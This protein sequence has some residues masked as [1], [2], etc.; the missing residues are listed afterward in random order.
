[1][2]STLRSLA[3][4][5]A[6]G[7]PRTSSPRV[8]GRGSAARAAAVA[9]A[10]VG[11]GS[12]P[13]PARACS[14]VDLTCPEELVLDTPD[15]IPFDGVLVVRP[16]TPPDP[17]PYYDYFDAYSLEPLL[18][19]K[20]T[21]AG[22]EVVEGALEA[23]RDYDF[24][25]W[26]PAAPLVPGESYTVDA[27]LD[28]T[29]LPCFGEDTPL[30]GSWTVTA[31]PDPAPALV[32]PEASGEAGAAEVYSFGF[33]SE[34]VC[35]NG[36]F[37]RTDG[38]SCARPA[39]WEKGQCA[40]ALGDGFL[41]ATVTLDPAAVAAGARQIAY[42]Y[43]FQPFRIGATTLDLNV[44]SPE[45]HS[46]TALHLVTGEVLVGPELCLGQDTPE[47]F[48]EQEIDPSAA[49]ATCVGEPYTCESELTPDEVRWDRTRCATWPSG[50]PIDAKGPVLAES[51]CDCRNDARAPGW[52]L[53]AALALFIRRRPC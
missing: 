41:R 26:R 49:L 51:G 40:P 13:T 11:A 31:A 15:V 19:V 14:S 1:M 30:V 8:F 23:P 42:S 12:L 17:D 38:T 9:G 29:T 44:F 33:L 16:A 24:F 6:A 25:V 4:T 46:V 37:P 3:P 5:R 34:L 21:R 48:G 22:G 20:V 10:L 36:A 28:R 7:L 39:T 52:T 43:D 18:S 35:C 32:L 2:R 53:L 47:V 27:S 50:E 45:C